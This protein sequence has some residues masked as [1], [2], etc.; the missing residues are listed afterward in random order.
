MYS[1]SKWN[2]LEPAF[3]NSAMTALMLILVTGVPIGGHLA[4]EHDDPHAA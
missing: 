4:K 3:Q 1:N 2:G